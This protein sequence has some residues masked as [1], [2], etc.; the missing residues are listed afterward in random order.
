MYEI[1]NIG[2]CKNDMNYN[3]YGGGGGDKRKFKVVC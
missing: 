2:S 3:M 1:I